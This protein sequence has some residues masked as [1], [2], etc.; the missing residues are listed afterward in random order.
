MSARRG[1]E[2]LR[3]AAVIV[4][5][6]DGT[7]AVRAYDHRMKEGIAIAVMVIGVMESSCSRDNAIERSAAK[8][9]SPSEAPKPVEWWCV[10][11]VGK[12]GGA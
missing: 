8:V 1:P 11:R 7:R 9:E 2:R 10:P 6:S 3:S 12:R 5:V 4:A